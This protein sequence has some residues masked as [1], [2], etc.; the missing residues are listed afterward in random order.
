MGNGLIVEAR[1]RRGGLALLWLRDVLVEVK[2]FSSHHIEAI[3]EGR[4]RLVGFYGH[5]EVKNRRLS[6]ALLRFLGT[7][8]DMPTVYVGDFNKV[9]SRMET[10]GGRLRPLVQMKG[11]QKVVDELGPVNLGFSG[12]RFTW[13]NNMVHPH[14]IK[15]RLDRGLASTSWV[16]LFTKVG[17]KHISCN[18]SDHSPVVL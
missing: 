7:R 14:T 6:W 1:G 11:L 12:Y 18:R 15:A 16:E 3:I 4:W 13:S 8:L 2:S 17:V 10:Q 5:H 9:L